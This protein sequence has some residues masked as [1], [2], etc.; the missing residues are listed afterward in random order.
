MPTID[1]ETLGRLQFAFT[2]SFHI[3]FPT[4]T[5]G[6][7]VFLAIVEARWLRTNNEIFLRLYHFWVRIFAL[8]FGMGVVSGLVLSY[9]FGTNWAEF[10][11]ISGPVLGQIGRASCREGVCQYVEISVVAVSLKKKIKNI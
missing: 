5:I 10:S 4:L 2:V 7:A 3:L 1:A 6:L 11:R 8:T 9:Q